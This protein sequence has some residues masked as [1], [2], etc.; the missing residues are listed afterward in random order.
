MN[1]CCKILME[2]FKGTGTLL[3]E[4]VVEKCLQEI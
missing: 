2:I 4:T 1:P 3:V